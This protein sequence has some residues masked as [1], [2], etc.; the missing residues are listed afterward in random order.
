[1]SLRKQKNLI[2][3]AA[4][5]ATLLAGTA[6]L[7]GY[8]NILSGASNTD[9]QVKASQTTSQTSS[10]PAFNNS[11]E[12]DVGCCQMSQ[13]ESDVSCRRPKCCSDD[14]SECCRPPE[15]CPDKCD[16]CCCPPKCCPEKCCDRG[17][18]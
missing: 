7:G 3:F 13:R 17:C 5:V 2:I 9:L 8:A 6:L 11:G 4:V 14:C 10:W 16:E 12:F 18:C 15:R 1:M